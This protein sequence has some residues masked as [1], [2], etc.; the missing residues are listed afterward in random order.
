MTFSGI[1]RKVS[2]GE[3]LQLMSCQVPVPDSAVVTTNDGRRASG[4]RS[5]RFMLF[6]SK[7]TWWPGTALPERI[8]DPEAAA[9]LSLETFRFGSAAR[10]VEGRE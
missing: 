4:G 10:S 9:C 5:A 2:Y 6:E 8:E 1:Y 7:E 3:V